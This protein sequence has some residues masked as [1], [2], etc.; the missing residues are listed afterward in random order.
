[1]NL[2]TLSALA[3]L[4]AAIGVVASLFYLAVQIRQNT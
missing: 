3:Q 4:I 2:E 1:V